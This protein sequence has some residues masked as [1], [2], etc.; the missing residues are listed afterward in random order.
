MVEDILTVAGTVLKTTDKLN[1][2]IV[3]TVYTGINNSSFTGLLNCLINFSLSFFMYL[4][5]KSGMNTSVGNELF[6]SY[7][8]NLTAYGV[9]A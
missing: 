5:N 6:K 1:E 2:L 9:K 7:S 3:Y 4:L 8:C